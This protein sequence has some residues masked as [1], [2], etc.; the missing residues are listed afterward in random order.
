MIALMGTLIKKQVVF[1]L[2]NQG[3]ETTLYGKTLPL[4]QNTP[5]RQYIGL[6]YH[7]AFHY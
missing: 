3:N 5:A 7:V 6:C 4:F 2:F 1:C